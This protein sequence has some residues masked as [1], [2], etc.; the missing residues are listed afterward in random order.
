MKYKLTSLPLPSLGESYVGVPDE[1]VPD[2]SM[3]LREILSRFTRGEA[4]PVGHDTSEGIQDEDLEKL[5]HADLVDKAEYMEKLKDV[6][7]T[8]EA[9]EKAKAKKAAEEAAK[10]AKAAEERRIRIAARKLAKGSSGG[11]A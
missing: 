8:H 4:V 5:K 9:Q 10:A 6:Q 2:Q 7:R 11:S 1:V 3:S